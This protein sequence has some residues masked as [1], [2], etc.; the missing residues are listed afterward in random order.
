MTRTFGK[1][2]GGPLILK[3]RLGRDAR[4]RRPTVAHPGPASRG[5]SEP[6]SEATV[7][8]GA[9]PGCL[10]TRDSEDRSLTNPGPGP[11]TAWQ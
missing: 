7:L 4:T 2:A 6:E 1:L 9:Q 5:D 11:V 3:W 10:A 8:S